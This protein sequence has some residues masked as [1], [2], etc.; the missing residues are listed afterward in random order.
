M[1]A[2]AEEVAVV[3]EEFLEAG[4]GYVGEFEFG[5]LGSAAGLA[6]F[7]DILFA[8]AGGLHHL[9]AGAGASVDE[10]VAETHCAVED[11]ARF[12][13]REEVFVTAVG[14][15]EA[16]GMGRMGRMG[17]IG[18]IGPIRPMGVTSRHRTTLSILAA[19]ASDAPARGARGAARS[20]DRVR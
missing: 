13:E 17:P 9:V 5:F 7:E 6:A 18:R 2:G 10:A 1:V 15:G 12:L 3:F 14:R 8:G 19:V 16:L 20:R 4:A 11:D